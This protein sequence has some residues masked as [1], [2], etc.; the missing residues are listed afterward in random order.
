MVQ[1]AV[2]HCDHCGVEVDAA[3][4]A[5]PL[6]GKPLTETPAEND[7]YRPV[8]RAPA[9]RRTFYQDLLVFL[10][11]FFMAGALALNLLNWNGTPWF[12]AVG[13]VL[14]AVWIE[15]RT[16]ISSMLI[17]TKILLQVLCV[18]LLAF[19]FDFVAG[20]S[21]WSLGIAFPLAILG[22]NVATDIYAYT[23]KSRWRASLF[24]GLLFA[25]LGF[26]PLGFYLGGITHNFLPMLLCL[27]SSGLSL[28]GMLRFALRVL[29]SELKKRLHL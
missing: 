3:L 22:A 14:L 11:I 2:N 28:L 10:G 19:S 9:A 15:L 29:R 27:I 6:C 5:C 1:R 16:F 17:G 23:Y 18:C 8:R 25:A 21:G 4:P 13:A 7:L 24:Y 26:L 12:L 20:W